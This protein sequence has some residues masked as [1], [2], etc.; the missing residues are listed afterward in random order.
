MKK[1]I[2]NTVIAAVLVIAVSSTAKAQKG[3]YV[4]IQGAPQLSVMF[5]KD[6]VNESSTDYRSKFS[7]TFGVGAGYHFSERL[8]IGTDAMYSIQ[9][10]RYLYN[11]LEYTQQFNYLKV[12]V[13]FTY[14]TDP[15]SRVMFTAKAGP[16]VGV[17]LKSKIS[18]ADDCSLNG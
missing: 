15:S 10:Q 7:S 14:N 18:N 5:N 9:K 1:T 8:G 16:Q 6:D 17:L 4:A 13:Y 3:F 12:P 11:H 2:F